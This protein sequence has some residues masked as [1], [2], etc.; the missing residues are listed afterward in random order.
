[1]KLAFISSDRSL[2]VFGASG[3]SSFVREVLRAV[4]QHADQVQLF[5]ARLDGDRPAGLENLRIHKLSLFGSDF[6][7]DDSAMLPAN[8]E[9]RRMLD[10]ARGR[11]DGV[12]ER[13]SPWCYAG[14]EYCR[15]HNIPSVLEITETGWEESLKVTKELQRMARETLEGASQLIAGS[16]RIV[17]ALG[18]QGLHASLIPVELTPKVTPPGPGLGHEKTFSQWA[19]WARW[20]TGMNYCRL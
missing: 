13:F 18:E 3:R 11:F 6:S 2:A 1:M 16:E 9:L 15:K 10:S 12:F 7:S 14:V 4:A 5:A 17:Q 8:R 19:I 20:T